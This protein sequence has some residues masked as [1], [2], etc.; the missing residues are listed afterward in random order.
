MMGVIICPEHGKTGIAF[1]CSHLAKM[2]A[3]NMPAECHE[4]RIDVE[5]FVSSHWFCL[6]CMEA[7]ALPTSKAVLPET[8]LDEF[9]AALESLRPVCGIC[10]EA[11]G[12][13]Q[14]G[15]MY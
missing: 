12:E 9:A 11:F 2:V 3:N 1:V 5:L 10:F 14:I 8:A 13:A 7:Y 4:L 6:D 15:T